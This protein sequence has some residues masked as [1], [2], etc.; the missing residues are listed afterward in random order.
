MTKIRV[1]TYNVHK[2]LGLDQRVKPA[3]IAE[4]LR[5]IKADVIGVQ[6][7]LSIEN[8]RKD[9]H[10]AQ[11]LAEELSMNLAM[12]DVRVLRGGLYGNAVLSRFPVRAHCRYDLTVR[13][14]EQRGCLRSDV[15]LPG[16]E[17]L[18]FFN[19]HLGTAFMERRHQARKLLEEEL[20]RSRNIEG[21]RVLVG[22]FNEWTRGLVS[23]LLAA[24]FAS[25]DIRLH[26]PW[27]NTY[28]G[29]LPVLHLDHIYYDNDLIVERVASHRSL[30]SLVASDH[31]PLYADFVLRSATGDKLDSDAGSSRA[32]ARHSE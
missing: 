9:Q 16:G 12:G 1:A 19:V 11:F 29:L 26:L 8:G 2:C 13:G 3:R 14:R 7:V 17:V 5:E 22:D 30:K 4:V 24:E 31:L 10:Q 21:P 18:H 15:L 32:T 20:I 27:R 6:E 25:A 23:Q 28:P